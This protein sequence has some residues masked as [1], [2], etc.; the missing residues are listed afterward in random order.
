MEF[1]KCF[2]QARFPTFS[3]LPNK[4]ENCDTFENGECFTKSHLNKLSVFCINP[5]QDKLTPANL[6]KLQTE[7][8]K[9]Y[10]IGSFFVLILPQPK[11]IL[12]KC[13]LCHLWQISCNQTSGWTCFN[14]FW[15]WRQN[16]VYLGLP[17][18]CF[19]CFVV[20][21]Q[22]QVAATGWSLFWSHGKLLQEKG[23]LKCK[24]HFGWEITIL[25]FA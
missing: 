7:F 18:H 24:I 15:D 1:V 11:N 5:L 19:C 16:C 3:I 17:S 22:Q 25:A 13:H 23:R 8:G 10:Q 2:T 12:H 6:W 4:N 9:S 14:A 21:H 20:L